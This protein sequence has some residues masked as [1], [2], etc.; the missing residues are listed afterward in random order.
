LGIPKG[1][2]PGRIGLEDVAAEIRNRQQIERESKKA[3]ALCFP[4]EEVLR[5][6]Q[7]ALMLP[8][9]NFAQALRL[10]FDLFGAIVELDKNRDLRAQHLWNNWAQN[11][12]H[13]PEGVAAI[14]IILRTAD[15]GNENDRR[16]FC[17][18][19]FS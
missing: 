14:N 16:M 18:R 9:L 10:V 8:L 4:F 15:G 5:L 13:G 2:L 6:G 19:P 12:I 17:R 11:V 7:F 3:V 1:R